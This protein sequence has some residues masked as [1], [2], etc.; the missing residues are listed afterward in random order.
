MASDLLLVFSHFGEIIHEQLV[1]TWIKL[2][3]CACF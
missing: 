2:A 3:M 1:S